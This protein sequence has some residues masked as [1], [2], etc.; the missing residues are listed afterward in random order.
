MKRLAGLWMVA[1][2]VAPCIAGLSGCGRP[3][4]YD[5][6]HARNWTQESMD[7]RFP[8]GTTEKQVFAKLGSP[9]YELTK[10][11]LTR[12]DYVGGPNAQQVVTFVFNNGKLVHKVYRAAA[13]D[14][15]RQPDTSVVSGTDG[16]RNAPFRLPGQ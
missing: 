4:T 10:D 6:I 8:L 14:T 9:F 5:E 15:Q 3:Q 11:G 12:W 16:V 2:L 13:P 1:A 7:Q